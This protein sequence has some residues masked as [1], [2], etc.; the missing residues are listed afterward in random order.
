ME[1]NQLSDLL[2]EGIS[3]ASGGTYENVKIDGVGKISDSIVARTFKG[4]GH[5]HFK[6]NLTAQEME[7]NGLLKVKGDL[8]FGNMETD[9]LLNVEG[10]ISGESCKLNGVISVK[11]DCELENFIGEG[12]FTVGG[13]L[14]AGQVE[15]RL[16]GQGKASEIGV[17]S[18]VIRQGNNSMWNKV[19]GE[20]IPKLKPE[21]HAGTI[22]G[23]RI[24]LEYTIADVVRG[25]EVI[26]G[27]GCTIA[28]VEYRSKLALHPK[29]NIGKAVKVSE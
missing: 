14:S 16:Q 6:A 15:F 13:L 27:Q 2:I 25:N 29:A 7:C 19:W 11:G 21:L 22:E 3:G 24:D 9:G 17:E 18:L 1:G 10:R 23:D 4:N 20:L 8:R 28:L 26:I 5:M 12:S